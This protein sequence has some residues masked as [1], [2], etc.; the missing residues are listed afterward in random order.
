MD[1]C[2]VELLMHHADPALVVERHLP[3]AWKLL[4]RM[5]VR[6]MGSLYHGTRPCFDLFWNVDAVRMVYVLLPKRA[7][8]FSR[9]KAEQFASYGCSA[10]G[11][12]DT[13]REMFRLSLRD[14]FSCVHVDCMLNMAISGG[15]VETVVFLESVAMPTMG[16]SVNRTFVVVQATGLGRYALAEWYAMS[17]GH[18]ERKRLLALSDSHRYGMR[19]FKKWAHVRWRVHMRTHPIILE[20][21]QEIAEH[22]R[23][24]V[25]R[26]LAMFARR[27]LE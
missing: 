9:A 27:G 4:L 5:S 7:D 3:D 22:E 1:T 14:Q 11:N 13:L 19:T 10:R 8:F 20:A 25:T 16:M 26:V 2:F 18:A 21:I 24:D 6:G 12:L 15:H 17:F 23:M